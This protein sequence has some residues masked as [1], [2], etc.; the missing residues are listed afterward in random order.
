MEKWRGNV[1]GTHSNF[2]DLSTA[3]NTT[4]GTVDL[5]NWTGTGSVVA[6]HNTNGNI[7]FDVNGQDT[8]V[9]EPLPLNVTASSVVAQFTGWTGRQVKCALEFHLPQTSAFK[10]GYLS[11][12]FSGPAPGYYANYLPQ[13]Q[14]LFAVGMSDAAG[15]LKVQTDANLSWSCMSG[16]YPYVKITPLR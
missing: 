13:A 11:L 7:A 5:R 1:L 9:Y 15:G 16:T 4:I 10:A 3:Q 14:S 8:S 12:S 2:V 6:G